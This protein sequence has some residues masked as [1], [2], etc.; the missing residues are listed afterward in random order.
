MP[1]SETASTISNILSSSVWKD[2]ESRSTTPYSIRALQKEEKSRNCQEDDTKPSEK[3]FHV[4]DKSNL[5]AAFSSSLQLI[6]LSPFSEDL[7]LLIFIIVLVCSVGRLIEQGFAWYTR[8]SLKPAETPTD[9]ISA[10]QIICCQHEDL[11]EPVDSNLPPT[12]T[13]RSV[14]GSPPVVVIQNNSDIDPIP[15]QVLSITTRQAAVSGPAPISVWSRTDANLIVYI[16]HC[17]F[18]SM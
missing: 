14:F 13:S 10:V 9:P 15:V 7:T 1:E 12:S 3:D 18:V 17:T 6:T 8:P 4:K 2:F 11:S 5:R 16:L